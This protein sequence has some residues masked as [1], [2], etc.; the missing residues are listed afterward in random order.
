MF[1][2]GGVGGRAVREA[3]PGAM[4]AIIN[5]CMRTYGPVHYFLYTKDAL[6]LMSG[7]CGAVEPLIRIGGVLTVMRA[8]NCSS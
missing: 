2:F 5:I 6:K 3:R 7:K 8:L 4:L 1:L